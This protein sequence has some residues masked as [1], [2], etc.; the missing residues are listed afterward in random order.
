MTEFCDQDLSGARFERVQLRDAS[1][2]H[3]ALTGARMRAVDLS[4]ADI[5]GAAL[6]G[7]RLNGLELADV[8]ITGELRNVVINGVDIAPLVEG[9]ILNV[10]FAH[11]RFIDVTKYLECRRAP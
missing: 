9:I 10:S 4:G 6:I 8:E 5:R 11:E 7:T 2:S 3:V 1:F